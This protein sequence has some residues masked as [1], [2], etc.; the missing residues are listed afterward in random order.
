MG[1]RAY[2]AYDRHA[3][4]NDGAILVFAANA[5]EAKKLAWPA[6]YG[7]GT[8]FFIDVGIRWLRSDCEHMRRKEGPHVVESPPSCCDCEMWYSE[9]LDS[10]GRCEGCAA[11]LDWE[12]RGGVT[13]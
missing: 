11:D 3:G 12:E 2:M 9:P 6:L 5:R 10:D 1:E 8:D 7:W 13:P 4:P